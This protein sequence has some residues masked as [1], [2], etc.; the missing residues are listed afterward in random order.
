MKKAI[1]IKDIAEELGLSRNTVSKALN[2]Q[3]VPNKT[4]EL[5]LKKAQQMNYKSFNNEI[6]KSKKY[7]ILLLTGKPIHNMNFYLPL[8][9]SLE[10]YCFDNNYDFFG[11]TYNPI[12]NSFEKVATY[13]RNLN[14]DGIVAIEC[15]DVE[16]I[17]KLLTL[18]LPTC[19]ID[20]AGHAFD[21]EENFDLINSTDQKNVC[22][23]IKSLINKYDFKYFSF[24]GDFRHCLSFHERYMGMLRGISRCNLNHST[25]DDILENDNTFDYGDVSLLKSKL[26]EFSRLPDCFVC[27]NDFVA[28]KVSNAI[29]ELGYEIPRDT[30]IIG[31]DGV[32]ESEE[33]NPKITTFSVD[34]T[35]LGEE[36]IRLL[37]GRINNH[38][39]PT[40][41]VSIQSKLIE[42]E[43]T[44]K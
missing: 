43:S 26:M 38:N 41:I 8:V 34:K 19:F 30:T 2:G 13:I 44:I 40:R 17:K 32:I 24:I 5:V 15:F 22:D 1:T 29:K 21:V 9:N 35:F 4:R 10:T 6:L 28:R 36:A 25:K 23:Y 16:F 20:F 42:R 11:Y 27:C 33:G 12:G 37:I 3:Y 39:C 7:R 18:K 14:V 31:Y